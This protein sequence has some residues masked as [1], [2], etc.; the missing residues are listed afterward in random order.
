MWFNTWEGVLIELGFSRLKIE[1]ED[2]EGS[3]VLFDGQKNMIT[4][5][6]TCGQ[7]GGRPSFVFYSEDI[8]GG[9]S[10]ANKTS[11]SPTIIA[12]SS[13]TGDPLAL[14]FQLKIMLS[15]ILVRS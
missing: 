9:A 13:Y 6:N 1:G 8:S 12:G 15:P 14:Y 4:L 7:R 10:S 3:V 2:C 5:D 11:Y